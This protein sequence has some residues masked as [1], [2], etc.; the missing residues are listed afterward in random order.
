MSEY[1][2][3][4]PANR[5]PMPSIATANLFVWASGFGLGAMVVLLGGVLLVGGGML[6]HDPDQA[7]TPAA[8]SAANAP[9]Q[10]GPTPAPTAAPAGANAP[11]TTGQAPSQPGAAQQR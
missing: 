3:P 9:T 4:D 10:P 5:T 7:R 8:Q 1:S 2:N 11:S 6:G